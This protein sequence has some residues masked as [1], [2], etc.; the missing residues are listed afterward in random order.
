MP[1]SDYKRFMNFLTTHDCRADYREFRNA[2]GELPRPMRS[3]LPLLPALAVPASA[4]RSPEGDKVA[5]TGSGPN[6][7]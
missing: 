7:N 2:K 5:S 3:I 6:Q 1:A 4:N